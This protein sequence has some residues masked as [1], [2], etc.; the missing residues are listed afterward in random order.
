MVIVCPILERDEVHS[1]TL[2]NTAVIISNTGHFSLC[3]V[4]VSCAVG[5]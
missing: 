1:G 2:H 5:G 4:C 3:M